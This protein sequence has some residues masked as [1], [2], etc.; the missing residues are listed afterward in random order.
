[1]PSTSSLDTHTPHFFLFFSYFTRKE[2]V[3]Q[4]K[5]GKREKEL[6]PGAQRRKKKDIEM[7]GNRLDEI[8]RF[9]LLA[10]PSLTPGRSKVMP[11]AAAQAPKSLSLSR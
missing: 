5:K 9:L 11:S 7:R 10:E 6:L 1:M 3:G 4:Y 2:H 8:D